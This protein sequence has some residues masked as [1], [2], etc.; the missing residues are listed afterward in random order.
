MSFQLL[1]IGAYANDGRGDEL[2]AA[3]AKINENYS[4]L[5]SFHFMNL[6]DSLPGSFF[7]TNI[8]FT[9][10]VLNADYS[11]NPYL[12]T[13]PENYYINQIYLK[14]YS[15]NDVLYSFSLS[16]VVDEYNFNILFQSNDDFYPDNIYSFLPINS[17]GRIINPNYR[18]QITN[19]ELL[20][21]KLSLLLFKP[22]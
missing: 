16:N 14:I 21:F 7:P 5:N 3:F 8:L 4:F 2:R 10:P 17:M 22:F 11:I 19:T 15:G 6:G 1:D 9:L 12:F 18:I 20:D 13:I